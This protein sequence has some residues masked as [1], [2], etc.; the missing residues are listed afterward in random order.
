MEESTHKGLDLLKITIDEAYSFGEDLGISNI[1]FVKNPAVITKGVAFSNDQ[2]KQFYKE[3]SKQRICAP[4]LIP[5]NIYRSDEFGEYYVQFTENVIEQI[6]D[7]FMMNLNNSSQIFNLEHNQKEEVPAYILET[8][9]VGNDPKLDRAYTEF[10]ID[11]PTGTFMVVSQITDK[12][13]YNQLVE[14]EQFAYSIEGFLG[15]E[16]SA[17]IKENTTKTNSQNMKI[18]DLED[19]ATYTVVDGKLIQL[20]ENKEDEKSEKEEEVEL[21]NDDDTKKEDEKEELSTEKEEEVELEESEPTTEEKDALTI[22]SI[23][24][25]LTPKFEEIYDLIAELKSEKEVELEESEKEDEKI[26]MNI[27][28]RFSAIQNFIKN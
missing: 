17:H 15:F 18:E 23:M 4:A 21:S 19:G 22:E 7:K 25:I 5:M 16:L 10:N 12:D 24:E 13:Y 27:H 11:V 1:A 2:K 3:N 14:N 20:S 9:I 8:W 6:R 26:E 28:Q